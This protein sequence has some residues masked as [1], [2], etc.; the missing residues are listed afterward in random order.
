[1]SSD[2]LKTSASQ[3]GGRKPM[4]PMTWVSAMWC[5]GETQS[6]HGRGNCD[7]LA[8]HRASKKRPSWL[9][10]EM[11]E[12]HSTWPIWTSHKCPCEHNLTVQKMWEN[13]FWK[14]RAMEKRLATGVHRSSYP[15]TSTARNYSQAWR[16]VCRGRKREG[17]ARLKILMGGS[18]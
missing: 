9:A 11:P 7:Q 10:N 17:W 1:M 18:R 14:L 8:L 6:F 4:P 2:T 5:A 16:I 15:W 3:V 12:E 13:Q